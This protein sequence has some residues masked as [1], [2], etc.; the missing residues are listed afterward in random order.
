MMFNQ[1]EVLG[2]M[3][4]KKIIFGSMFTIF[5][6]L[7]SSFFVGAITINN[8]QS[9]SYITSIL[10]ENDAD[11]PIWK[12]GDSWTYDIEIEG[13]QNEYFDLEFDLYIDNMKFEV[14]EIQG[15]MY[16]LSMDVPEGDFN[17]AVT[18]DLGAFTFSGNIE[19]A[20]LDGFMYVK[21]STLGIHK[22]EGSIVGDT[23]KLIL[24]HFDIDFQIEFEVEENNQGVKTNFSSLKFPMN[25][26][27]TWP[28]PQTYLNI[29]IN[30]I[31]PN[32]GQNRLFSYV[33]DHDVKCMGWETLKI[34]NSIYDALKISGVNLGDKNDFWYSAAAGNIV[35]LDYQNVPLGFGYILNS[36]TFDLVSTTFEAMSNP[37][38]IP[39]TPIGPTDIFVGESGTYETSSN[40][41]DGNKIK[42]IVDWG[43]GSENTYSDFIES[44]QTYSAGHTWNTK[45]SHEIRIKARDKFGKESDWSESLTVMV[46]NNDPNKPSIPD[47]PTSGKIKNSYTYSTSATDLDG[48]R[49]KYGFDWDGDDQVDDWT[50]LVNSGESASKSHTWTTQGN[51]EIKVKAQDEYGAESEWSD[52]LSITMPKNKIVSVNVIKILEQHP[53]L[54]LLLQYIQYIQNII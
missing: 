40:D 23:N 14:L 10:D 28:I 54:S 8:Y 52:P 39:S 27:D 33:L 35:K 50:S 29:S 1:L 7:M 46:I 9:S 31:Q 11:L 26:D 48:H 51:Y 44:G 6:L 49:V 41:P 3:K 17:G 42:Y 38:E 15:D 53:I 22:C 20:Y 5:L 2:S 45:G 4:K 21:K 24:P 34:D 36:L 30:A 32:L 18:A 16:K 13:E 47:G 37:P 43:D 19:E 12:V 25:T